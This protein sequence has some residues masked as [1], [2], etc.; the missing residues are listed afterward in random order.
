[1]AQIE[2]G[3]T[4]R[5]YEN[6]SYSAVFLLTVGLLLVSGVWAVWDDYISRRPWKQYQAQFYQV[7]YNKA[8][9]E[10]INEEE[11]LQAD[12]AYQEAREKLAEAEVRM[13]SE[14]TARHLEGLEATL[15]AA[16]VRASDLENSLRL[17]KSELD[18]A[19]YEYEHAIQTGRPGTEERRVID[20]LEEERV[21]IDK[22]FQAAQA[23]SDR[24]RKEMD[25]IHLGVK[26]WEDKL[27]ELSKA[28]GLI[29]QRMEG[30]VLLSFNG[31]AIP[32]IPKIAQVVLPEFD[33]GNFG[34]PLL[35]VDRCQSC[36]IGID[37]GG[38][39]DQPHPLKT[40][41][42]RE[43]IFT[44]HPPEKF[45]CTPCHEGQGPAVNSP[46]QAHGEVAFW[47]HPLRRGAKVEANCI[48]CHSNIQNV[49]HAQT[50][51][52]GEYLFIQVGCHGCHLVEGY[53][54]LP[55][56][57]PSLRRIAAKADPSWMVRWVK[58]PREFRPHTRMPNFLFQ[59]EEATAVVTYLLDAS[60]KEGEQWLSSHLAPEGI[61]PSNSVLVEEGRALVD[62]LGCRGCHGFA[63]GE[64]AT[65][66]G[67]GKDFAPNLAHIAEKVDSRWLYHW[68]R[69][70][71]GYSPTTVMPSLRLTEYEARAITSYLMTLGE[72][73]PAP[74]T[75][76]GQD[77]D[78]TEQL[79][80]PEAIA[81]GKTLVRKY[82]CF[83]CHDIPGMENEARIGVELTT[84]G[85]KP[86]EEIFFGNRTDIP[87]A[88]DDWTYHKLKTPRTYATE[89]IEQLMPQFDFADE[90]IIALRV[91]LTSRTDHK[92]P[93]RYLADQTVQARSIVAG[94]RLVAR[95]N[96]VGCHEIEGQGGYIRK[97]YTDNPT[98]APPVL[99]SEGAKVQP[100]WLFGFVKKPISLRPWLRVRM[101][102][103][104]LSDE[105]AHTLVDYFAALDKIE[106]PF[107][108]VDSEAIPHEHIEAA[109]ML[110]SKDYFDCFSC[111]Q[112][113]D[114]KPEGPP[115]GWAP[116]LALAKHRLNPN[117]II[118]W[119]HD[120]QKI[121]PGTKMPSFYPGGPEDI[122]SGNEEKQIEAMR[123]YLMV[124]GEEESLL[125][126][127]PTDASAAN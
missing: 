110:M 89:R 37:R 119:L 124:L 1:M 14:E 81:Q 33:H 70:P 125:A 97:Y 2:S 54:D 84:F 9:Q 104:G 12:P 75:G 16:E 28:K 121:Q 23:E 22:Q 34:T 113:G 116:D 52:Q 47:E 55:K 95:Y 50:I 79:S 85:S 109:R 44:P 51:A 99:S 63:E 106:V 94:G 38:F 25:E 80:R 102:T 17:V 117:W 53:G 39:E 91:F 46:E 7:A 71:K 61:D 83:G 98:F 13:K 65:V 87:E 101:P 59:G 111:H 49:A 118:P 86:L 72:K 18:A 115:E 29:W 114:K 76:L 96:C 69:D 6:K 123:D 41:P 35:R 93:P 105:E 57:G 19:W 43:A 112:Q 74:L 73:K 88:W 24:I 20:E 103:F 67:Q 11:R 60:E 48:K 36:H 56:I 64:T 78:L 26:G 90:D 92:I 31:F 66:I 4:E 127:G 100:D 10:L 15:A 32:Q 108:Y 68:I 45:G 40:H 120:P 5:P 8:R 3:G 58:N 30:Y 42:D 27:K 107:V 77:P 122:L 21:A 62:S 82:G 126:K